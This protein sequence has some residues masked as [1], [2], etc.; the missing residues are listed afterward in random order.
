MGRWVRMRA[1][2]CLVRMIAYMRSYACRCAHVVLLCT[3]LRMIIN[4]VVF[5]CVLWRVACLCFAMIAL[6]TPLRARTHTYA[7]LADIL[8][9]EAFLESVLSWTP[10]WRRI[11]H[12]LAAAPRGHVVVVLSP[13][14]A[15]AAALGA[16]AGGGVGGGACA[17]C[18]GHVPPP[19]FL[20]ARP[21]RL[22]VDDDD[23]DAGPTAIAAASAAAAF[24]RDAVHVLDTSAPSIAALAAAGRRVRVVA[25]VPAAAEIDDLLPCGGGG[26]TDRGAAAGTAR[27]LQR[28]CDDARAVPYTGPLRALLGLCPDCAAGAVDAIPSPSSVGDAHTDAAW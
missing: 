8:K 18:G 28:T 26:G 10:T 5:A 27:M 16:S 11:E 6:R 13:L 15:A 25:H 3:N 23:E 21:R 12:V 24:T 14:A 19:A 20:V 7:G 9:N 4:C 1:S 22:R 2:A 17:R